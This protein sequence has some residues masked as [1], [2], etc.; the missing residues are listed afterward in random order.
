MFP[1]PLPEKG[2]ESRLAAKVG[3]QT[4]ATQTNGAATV[5]AWHASCGEV[6]HE[7]G[8]NSKLHTAPQGQAFAMTSMRLSSW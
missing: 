6:P 5:P 4:S 7:H 8:V 2:R 1:S 3:A